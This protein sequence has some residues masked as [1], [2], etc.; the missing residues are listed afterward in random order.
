MGSSMDLNPPGH[1]EMGCKLNNCFLSCT[2]W[3][4]HPLVPILT[5]EVVVDAGNKNQ[6]EMM[7]QSLN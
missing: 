6:L 3:W 4:T 1:N 7:K 2:G 5:D